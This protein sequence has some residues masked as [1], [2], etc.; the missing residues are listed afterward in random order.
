MGEL[1]R[2]RQR[3]PYLRDVESMLGRPV[4]E[5]GA[6][7]VWY[8]CADRDTAGKLSRWLRAE[9]KRRPWPVVV[10]QYH[11]SVYVWRNLTPEEQERVMRAIGDAASTLVTVP[12]LRLVGGRRKK[13]TATIPK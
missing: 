8:R 9:C 6:C 12:R 11:L 7:Q 10:R 1:V 4:E 13:R 3:D 5:P 2:F